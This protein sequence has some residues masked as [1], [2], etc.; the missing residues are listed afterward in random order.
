[1]PE[2]I[3]IKSNIYW[4]AIRVIIIML[5]VTGIAYPL[6]LVAI[7]QGILP[8]QS[9][10]SLI[11]TSAG[12]VIGSSLIAQDFKSPKFFHTR[13]QSDAASGVD[14]D[15]T[16]DYARSQIGNVSKAT[17]IPQ[18]PLS[19]LIE[20]SVE[21]SRSSNLIA[22]SPDYVNVLELNLELVKQYPS[23]YS[24]FLNSSIV[25]NSRIDEQG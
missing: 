12:K 1:M 6:I 5:L 19:T 9:G 23:T 7:G 24:E 4:P 8:F 3:G 15:I 13:N 14:P 21:K 20:L 10:G 22:F 16:P 25:N 11:K 17:G 2:K 18:N